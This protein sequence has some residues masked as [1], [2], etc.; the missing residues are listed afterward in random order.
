MPHLG[1]IL[2]KY[3][4]THAHTQRVVITYN[5]NISSVTNYLNKI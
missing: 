3:I 1:K 2:N 5:S 4:D